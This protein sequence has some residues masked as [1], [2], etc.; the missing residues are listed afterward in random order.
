M[1]FVA[2]LPSA[3]ADTLI[4]KWNT[5]MS[6][7]K[8]TDHNKTTEQARSNGNKA[9]DAANETAETGKQVLRDVSERTERHAEKS[10]DVALE[11][12]EDTGKRLQAANRSGNEL[13]GF[14]LET[15]QAQTT[16]NLEAMQELAKARDW[17]D[18]LAVQSAFFSVSLQRLQDI[19][20][21]YMEMTGN[22]MQGQVEAGA[23]TAKKASKAAAA[24]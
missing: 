23:A 19:F 22:V 5:I 2:P 1:R 4:G 21:R 3:A 14:W 11:A 7:T 17:Q 24:A 10:M 9:V 13:A 15:M 8:S 6:Q 12:V 16:H 20:S 18:K